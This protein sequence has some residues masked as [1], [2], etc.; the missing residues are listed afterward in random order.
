M[1]LWLGKKSP[2]EE[3][4]NNFSKALE[5]G[6]DGVEKALEDIPPLLKAAAQDTLETG[7]VIG[8]VIRKSA[9]VV[10]TVA[11]V[12]F[13]LSKFLPPQLQPPV[14][15]A[16]GVMFSVA[17]ILEIIPEGVT[18]DEFGERILQGEEQGITLAG[19]DDNFDEYVRQ[20]MTLELDK[21]KMHS[22]VEQSIASAWIVERGLEL[23]KPGLAMINL[24]PYI[25]DNPDEFDAKRLR[26]YIEQA[27]EDGIELGS[28][29]ED[30]YN[31]SASSDKRYEAG[32]FVL[33]AEKRLEQAN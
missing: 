22:K 19:C 2:I 9:P 33:E 16:A 32:K 18:A 11:P 1:D 8:E 6:K 12:V 3:M 10:K 21:E 14:I 17:S 20:L 24:V 28:V 5:A 7:K 30:F 15:L 23:K 27:Q 4:L 26:A 25:M 13:K 29:M 31:R